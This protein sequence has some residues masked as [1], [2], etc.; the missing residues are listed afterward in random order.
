MDN[1]DDDGD[2]DKQLVVC[3]RDDDEKNIQLTHNHKTLF[4][5]V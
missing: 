1:Y 3:E 5:V 2:D 4:P